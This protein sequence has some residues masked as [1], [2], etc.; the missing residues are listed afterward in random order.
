MIEEP[1]DPKD[2]KYENEKDK[3]VYKETKEYDSASD[4]P[5]KEDESSTSTEPEAKYE[6]T[7]SKV[8]AIFSY[9]T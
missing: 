2:D 5:G 4:K 9:V 7:D 6:G 3:T 8:R 1:L